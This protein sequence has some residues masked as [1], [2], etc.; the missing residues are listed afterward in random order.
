MSSLPQKTLDFAA[1]P[2]DRW[3]GR[4]IVGGKTLTDFM[5]ISEEPSPDASWTVRVFQ[6]E[7]VPRGCLGNRELDYGL[8]FCAGFGL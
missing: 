3:L 4:L 6:S 5:A 8:V 2:D 7:S 1:L